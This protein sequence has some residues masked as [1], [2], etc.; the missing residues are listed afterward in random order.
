[1]MKRQVCFALAGVFVLSG[2]VLS[3][4]AQD[5]RRPARE[6]IRENIHR[7]RLLRMTEAL[8][9]SEEQ[10]AKIYPVATRVEKDKQA[11]LG[12]INKEMRRLQGLVDDADT[13][14]AELL[15]SFVKIRDLR[16]RFQE[17]DREFE[18]FLAEK[19]SP[20]QRAKYLLFSAEFYRRLTEGLRGRR[21]QGRDKRPS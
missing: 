6:R 4:Q 2:L 20:V 14:E 8:G 7:L 21:P 10:T 9:L 17:R 15:A 3:S 5:Q 13:E 11:L 19:L 18:D 1:M 16:Q 12:E